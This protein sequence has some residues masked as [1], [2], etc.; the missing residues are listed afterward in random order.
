MQTAMPWQH[1]MPQLLLLW[2]KRLAFKESVLIVIAHLQQQYCSDIHDLQMLVKGC[3]GKM[4][5]IIFYIVF[6]LSVPFNLIYFVFI[7]LCNA[8]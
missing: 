1:N 8:I 5:H 6:N 3:C 4:Q 7:R 2:S